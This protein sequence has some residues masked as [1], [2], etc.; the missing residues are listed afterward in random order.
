[1]ELSFNELKNLT[2]DFLHSRK[3]S[4]MTFDFDNT[5]L[6][7]SFKPV[8]GIYCSPMKSYDGIDVSEWEKWVAIE[9]FYPENFIYRFKISLKDD[10]RILL[11][12]NI[13]HIIA[14][15]KKYSIDTLYKKQSNGEISSPVVLNFLKQIRSTVYYYIRNT[16]CW[17]AVAL[18]YNGVFFSSSFYN[19]EDSL[20][21]KLINISKESLAKKNSLEK[22]EYEKDDFYV[23]TLV[24]FD[25]SFMAEKCNPFELDL[26]NKRDLILSISD[27]NDE[28]DNENV[29]C[30]S[31]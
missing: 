17:P 22:I 1:M 12:L 11:I 9:N 16:I 10:A 31:M 30:H 26:I 27:Q 7:S 24:V 21:K 29:T 2:G 28:E 8:N 19:D 4:E 6:S 20:K 25:K 18:D 3:K 13:D 5:R 14:L 23:N 15:R